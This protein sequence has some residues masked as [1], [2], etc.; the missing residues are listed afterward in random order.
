MAGDIAAGTPDRRR[1]HGHAA[2]RLLQR[3]AEEL[4]DAVDQ[5]RPD[6]VRAAERLHRD[7]HRHG[8]R[9]RRRSTRVL[10]GDILYVG[11]GGPAC[12]PT[13][14]PTTITTSAR[15]AGRRPEGRRWS[16]TTQSAANGLPPAATAGV[17][18]TRAAAQAFFIAGTNRAMFRFTLINHLCTRPGAG[19]RTRRG[20]RTASAR[21]SAAAPGGDSRVFLNNCIGCHS[22]MDPMAQAF[23]YYNYDETAGR[24]RVHGGR[25]AAEV[26]HQQGQLPGGL[27]HA[28]RP[29]GQLLAQGPQLAARLGSA[30][31]PGSGQRR[32]VARPRARAQ[33]R[34]RRAAR[35]RRSSRPSASATRATRR[36]APRSRR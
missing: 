34:L 21:T 2:P 26:L 6:G 8:A 12:R 15:D 27:R 20:R 17:M 31:L 30:S 23:A 10:S 5:S 16:R 35:W 24:A 13:R 14:R 7:R 18:T 4:R 36:T 11:S 22:G 28:G 9:R 19:A 32:Q 1:L 29:L 33:R 3:D 25:G